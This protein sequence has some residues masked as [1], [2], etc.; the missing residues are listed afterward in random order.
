M[1][2]AAHKRFTGVGNERILENLERIVDAGTPVV[3]RIPVVPGHN[4][5]GENL[6]A[7]AKYLAEKLGGRVI[8]VQLLPFRKLGIE[9][10]TA[11][12]IP[13]PMEDFEAPPREVW[14]KDIRRFADMMSSYGLNA[15]AGSGARIPV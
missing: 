4:G 5:T 12:G 6:R 2:S 11:L 3:I 14:E 7:T 15:V 10:Y 1:D 8:Q 9:K 13:Y